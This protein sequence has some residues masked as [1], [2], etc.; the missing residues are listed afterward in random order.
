MSP[1]C[2][3]SSAAALQHPVELATASRRVGQSDQV[4]HGCRTRTRRPVVAVVRRPARPTG[5]TLVRAVA[6]RRITAAPLT[7]RHCAVTFLRHRSSC[8]ENQ[9]PGMRH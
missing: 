3:M 6:R 8:Q 1:P 9:H 5:D 7:S 2:L 4:G